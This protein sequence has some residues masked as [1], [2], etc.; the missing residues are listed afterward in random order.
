MSWI[1]N[2]ILHNIDP[3][4]CR[5]RVSLGHNELKLTILFLYIAQVGGHV[6]LSNLWDLRLLTDQCTLLFYLANV[7]SGNGLTSTDDKSLPESVLFKIHAT[8]CTPRQQY[9]N[10]KQITL[11]YHMMT[12]SNGN[13]FRVT[14]PSCGEFTGHRRIP[15]TKASGAELWCFLD[16]RLNKR[17][18]KQSWIWWFETPTRPLWRHRNETSW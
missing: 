8:I 4:V 17:L 9:A 7:V 14:G 5:H 6:A 10:T 18:C 2:L 13:I 1:I 16:L 15:L 12:S 11:I 3:H